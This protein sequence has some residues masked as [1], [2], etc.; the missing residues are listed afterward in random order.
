MPESRRPLVQCPRKQEVGIDCNNKQVNQNTKAGTNDNN[1]SVVIAEPAEKENYEYQPKQFVNFC[2]KYIMS[3][4]ETALFL[5]KSTS[6]VYKNAKELGGRKLGG[7]LVFPAKEDLYGRIFSKE[8]GV[9]IRLH[10]PRKQVHRSMVQNKNRSETGR[11]KKARG[12]EK[13]ETR[14][15]SSDRHG[16][17]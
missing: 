1:N 15:R 17:L 12:G 13:S 2:G 9:E 14:D 3:V 10:S 11:S 16:L 4:E 7:S 8:E 5:R 6:W